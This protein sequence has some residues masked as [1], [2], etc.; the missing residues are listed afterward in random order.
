MIQQNLKFIKSEIPNNIKLVVVT[1]THTN[2]EIMEV[3]KSG[4]KIMGEN[5]PQ[6]L[7]GKHIVLPKDIEWHFIGHLQTNKVKFLA[8][9]VSLI[10]AV[11]SLK[12]L[13][14]INKEAVK[15]NRTINC[16]LQFH[17]ATEE[18]KFGLNKDEA[19]AILES[20]DFLELKNIRISGI[21]G[22][23]TYT[24]NESQ[25]REEFKNLKEIY[26]FLKQNFFPLD[27]NFK[28]I[29]MGMTN[30]YKI[31]VEEGATIL[32]IGSAIFS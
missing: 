25:I 23:A 10:H 6:E 3:Y 21:M 22:M 32:R 1:K 13:K 4:H 17:I 5:K 28:E 11:D 18:T 2:N 14:T 31:A 8:P 29:S 19:T 30:D 7:S 15:N 16:L 26:S 20:P 9:F 24:Q 27:S 12:L